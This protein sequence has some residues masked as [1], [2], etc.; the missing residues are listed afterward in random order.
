[1]AVEGACGSLRWL[2]MMSAMLRA[3]V[4][5]YSSPREIF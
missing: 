3:P 4:A 1:M 5:M 2:R